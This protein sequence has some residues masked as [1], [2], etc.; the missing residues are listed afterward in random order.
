MHNAILQDS[1][2]TPGVSWLEVTSWLLLP[3]NE[4]KDPVCS[5]KEDLLTQIEYIIYINVCVNV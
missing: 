2:V 1:T 3:H 5:I 4:F